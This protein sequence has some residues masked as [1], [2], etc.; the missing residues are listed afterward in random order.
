[1][2]A[3]GERQ[4]LP[5]MVMLVSPG[6]LAVRV[7][8]HVVLFGACHELLEVVANPDAGRASELEDQLFV[9]AEKVT[10]WPAPMPLT[11]LP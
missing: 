9:V 5:V 10:V 11:T 4:A 2:P 3:E 1:M 6:L 8:L 7:E